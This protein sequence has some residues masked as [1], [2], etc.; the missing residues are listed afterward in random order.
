MTTKADTSVKWFHS[1][2]AD[3]PVLRGQAGALIELLDACLINGFSTRSPDSVV[4]AGGVATVSISAGNPYD[5]HAVIA[6]SGASEAALNAEWRIDTSAATSF[7]FLCPGVADGTVTGAALK[8]AGAGWSKPFADTNVAVYQSLDPASTQL[9][10]R[11]NDADA[12]YTRVR[13]YEQM[14]D[15]N[16]GTGLFP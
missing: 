11:V 14:T 2:M 7:T 9:Y 4:V 15:A 1:G 6:I 13:G 10:L 8:R 5:K 12:R 16:T 3:A